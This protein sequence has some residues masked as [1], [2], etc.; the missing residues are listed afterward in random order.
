MVSGAFLSKVRYQSRAT[1]GLRALVGGGDSLF[2][3]EQSGDP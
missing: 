1:T 3:R 2:D